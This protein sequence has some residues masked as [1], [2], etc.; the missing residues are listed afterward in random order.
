[1]ELLTQRSLNTLVETSAY[2]IKIADS[3]AEIEAALRLRFDV[4]NIEMKE[5]LQSSFETG[6]DSDVYDTFCDHIIVKERASG[7]I[8]GTYR[9]LRQDVAERN[10]GFYSEGEFDLSRF[11]KIPGQ[12]LELGR[13]CVAKEFRSIAVINLLWKGIARY[14]ELHSID[15]LFGCASLHSTKE[16]EVAPAYFYLMHHHLAPKEYRVHPLVQHRMNFENCLPNETELR[17]AFSSLPPLLKGYLRLGAVICGE[18]ARDLE[19]G[20]TDFLILLETGSITE[21]YKSHYCKAQ[22]A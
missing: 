2:I 7:N 6:F 11:K 19:F 21:R 12:S 14:I 17:G 10:I 15:H 9:L 13:S 20:T 4:F 1:M 22:A 3:L 16:R 8:V 5:G 18:P